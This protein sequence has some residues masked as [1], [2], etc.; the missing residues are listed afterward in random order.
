MI[1]GVPR[2]VKDDEYRVGLVPAGVES[3]VAHGH[4]VLIEAG[5]GLGSGIRDEDY[6]EAGA[7]LVAV[8]EDVYS[9]A[10]MIV[11]VKEPLPQ[12][13]ALIRKDQIVYTYFHFAASEELTNAMLET[14]SINIAY[15]TMSPD[16]R[17]LPCLTPMSEVAGRMAVQEGAKYLE[18]PMEGRGILL[19]GVP[20]VHPGDVV[21]IGG[22]VVGTAAAKIAA[23]MG[24]NVLLLD[25]NLERLRY[26]DDVLPPNVTTL[27]S[28]AYNIRSALESADL[29]IG[30]VLLPGA[31][32]PNLIEQKDLSLMPQGAVLVD[33]AVDQ[34]GCVETT[35]PTTHSN[36]VYIVDGV[37]HY[38]VANM[39]GA[40]G[41]T[42]TF[43]L[44][45]VTTPW[46]L[47]IANLGWKEAAR[48]HR[49]ISSGLNVIAGKCVYEAVAN[50]FEDIPYVELESFLS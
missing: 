22:G 33:V 38:C 36:P 42:S 46:A 40:V 11:K 47:Q 8:A 50:T 14:G 13:Y 34:G 4:Q 20:G 1:I 49:M 37:V 18:R 31:K 48:K 3:L 45:N 39:P 19:G 26:L 15:E 6:E 32:A 17:Q 7:K 44:T 10:D 21:I 2:E 35:R 5:A 30:A 16:G 27:Y 43:A 25:V 12:E 41:R 29:L 28:N 23:G 24:A 9:E